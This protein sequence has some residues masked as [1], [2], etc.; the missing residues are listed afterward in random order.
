MGMI[1]MGMIAWLIA[2]EHTPRVPLSSLI[3]PD[4]LDLLDRTFL[5]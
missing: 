2:L 4:L 1:D 3:T 5:H